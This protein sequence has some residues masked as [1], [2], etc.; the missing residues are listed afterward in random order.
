MLTGVLSASG[1]D[2]V[3]YGDSIKTNIDLVQQ[4]LGL[5]QQ[6]DVLVDNM[7][8]E[9]HLRLVCELKNLP[10]ADVEETISQSL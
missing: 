1:G 4:K 6:F 10:P 3:V 7:T 8:V 5:C 9:E 2:A